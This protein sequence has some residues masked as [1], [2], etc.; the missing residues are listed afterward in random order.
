VIAHLQIRHAHHPLQQVLPMGVDP[1][2]PLERF[3]QQIELSTH[4]PLEGLWA[5]IQRDASFI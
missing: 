4:H 3:N 5:Q 2:A 1:F